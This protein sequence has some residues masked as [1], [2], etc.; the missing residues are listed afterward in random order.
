VQ[1][2]EQRA[3]LLALQLPYQENLEERFKQ[4]Q[5]RRN[6]PHPKRSKSQYRF[7]ALLICFQFFFLNGF[8]SC[9]IIP[10]VLKI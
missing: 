4:L 7:I 2:R 5:R 8:I 1:G 3:K 6:D 9:H 10:A